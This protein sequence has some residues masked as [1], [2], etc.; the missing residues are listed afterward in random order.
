ML[1]ALIGLALG[2]L[3]LAS[4]GGPADGQAVRHLRIGASGAL[5][6]HTAVVEAGRARG[7]GRLVEGLGP[8]IRPDEI[9][10]A[11]LET[12]LSEARV[13]MRGDPPRL[14]APPEVAAA[15]GAIGLDV[16]S[17][18]NN[19][20]WD[21]RAE[22]MVATLAALRGAGIA[23]VGAAADP[24]E[25]PGPVVVE[26]GGL[27]VAFV[28]FTEILQGSP[29]TRRP[30][31][32]I[33]EW[34]PR[35]ARRALGAARERA[36]VVVASIHWGLAYRSAP[37]RSQRERAEDLV[38][39]GADVILGHGPH[40]LQPV[41]RLVSPRGEAVVAYS[42]GNLISNQGYLFRPRRRVRAERPLRDPAT[43]DGAWL[44]ALLAV[45]PSG[46]VRVEAVRA[47]PLWTA[48]NWYDTQ[49]GPR[50]ERPAPDIRVHPLTDLADPDLR[51][52]RARAI[53]DTLGP[54]VTVLGP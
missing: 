8:V 51:A 42:L 30:P 14:G 46:A 31:V 11:N 32:R 45:E 37:R 53:R 40:V 35:L 34:D 47:V 38:R 10:F 25:A 16:L 12:P 43:R 50:A 20:A 4:V 54:S 33:A 41:E 29:G 24:A 17:V 7:F 26:A 22:G 23:P 5:L 18:A 9:A 13:P 6:L 28:A 2:L 44:R 27:R 49:R 48:N 39:L 52:R 36:D 19:H 3:L 15:L 1:R 21:Q